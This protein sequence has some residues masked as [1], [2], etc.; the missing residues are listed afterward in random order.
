MDRRASEAKERRTVLKLESA[1]VEKKISQLLDRIVDADNPPV[2]GAYERRIGELERDKL[3]LAENV[4][5]CGTP[6]RDDDA[7]F[8]T[9]MTLPANL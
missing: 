6:A 3:L 9:S 5:R 1:A 4:A 2:I 8:Q 7:V